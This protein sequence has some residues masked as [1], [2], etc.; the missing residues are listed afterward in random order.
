M[1]RVETT[2]LL[3]REGNRILLATKKR[4]F[5]EGKFNGIGGKLKDGESPEEAMIRESKEEIDVLPTKYEKMA[6]LD[7]IEYYK[8]EKENVIMH[9]YVATEWD[10]EPK[11]S[12][13]MC[14]M[15]FDVE[16][17][18]YDRMFVDDSY[19]LPFVLKRKKFNAFFEFDEDWNLLSKSIEEI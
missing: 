11:E 2:L 5:G 3:L 10:G 1:K 19:W 6:V 17:I 16:D 4:G 13:E 14:P 15:W 8:G 12:E 18:P 7:F 9:L